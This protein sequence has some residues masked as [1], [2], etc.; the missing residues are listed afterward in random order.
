MFFSKLILTLAHKV[1]KGKIRERMSELQGSVWN[2]RKDW[3]EEGRESVWIQLAFIRL[4]GV[5]FRVTWHLYKIF[6]KYLMGSYQWGS[7]IEGAH[8]MY[9]DIM[10]TFLHM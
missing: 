10:I 8:E 2:G 3:E 7:I 4:H 9:R 5:V 1:Y 6:S